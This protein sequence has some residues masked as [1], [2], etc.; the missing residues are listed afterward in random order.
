MNSYSTKELYCEKC[1]N[2]KDSP[3]CCTKEM[4]LDKYTFFCDLCGKEEKVPQCCG[5]YMKLRDKQEK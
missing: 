4:Q 2:S 1:G 3:I 5:S